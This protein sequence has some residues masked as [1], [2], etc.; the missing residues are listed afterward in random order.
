MSGLEI[1][2]QNINQ[3]ANDV[4]AAAP[5]FDKIIFYSILAGAALGAGLFLYYAPKWKNKWD[6][7]E[8]EKTRREREEQD[9]VEAYLDPDSHV[10]V[11]GA[12]DIRQ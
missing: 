2:A 1:I 4:Y 9:P 6:A 7:R 5:D 11:S 10:G 8:K 12:G 3:T